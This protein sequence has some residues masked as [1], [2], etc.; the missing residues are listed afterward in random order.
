[1]GYY[2]DYM[3][4][5]GPSMDSMAVT[6]LMVY[7][8]ILLIFGLVSLIGYIVKA[9]GIYT[10]AK[11]EGAEYPWL[12]F[13]PFARTYLQGEL[14]G[15]IVLKKKSIQSPGIWLLVLPFVQG[16]AVFVLYLVMFGVV[17]F[18]AFSYT[19][20][21]YYSS[22]MS[23]GT[24]GLLILLMIVFVV[25]LVIFSAAL[26]VLRIL[27][28]CQ[29]LGK[30]T[31]RNMSVVHAVLMG[32]IPLYEPICFLVMSRKPY[33]PGM[34]PPE[35]KPF[36]QT[37]PENPNLYMGGPVQPVTGAPVQPQSGAEKEDQKAGNRESGFVP[38]RGLLNPVQPEVQEPEKM[39]EIVQE[40]A[41]QEG[42][43]QKEAVQEET[44]QKETVQKEV[45]QEET[46]QKEAVQEEVAQEETVQKEAAQ[47]ETVQ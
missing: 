25:V 17:G 35:V 23:A 21:G 30:F 4:D 9:I 44:V 27:V 33:N 45:A 16:A 18:S 37:P 14:A 2:N 40:E 47:E 20:S 39:E 8:G 12:S 34:E 32:V 1:M 29:I 46:A 22:G 26:Q 28:N 15:A 5:Y 11:R 36:M 42:I 7:L 24:I 19:A 31:S 13:V 6:I 43:V 41:T 38:Q 3:Y 10:I